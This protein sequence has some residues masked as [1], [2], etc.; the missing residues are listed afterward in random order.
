M[1]KNIHLNIAIICILTAATQA[2]NAQ[3]ITRDAKRVADGFYKQG[4]Y[5]SAA[6]Y[7]EQSLTGNGTRPGTALYQ[8]QRT[9]QSGVK[10]KITNTDTYYKLGESYRLLNNYSQAEGWYERVVKEAAPAYPLAALYYGISLRANAKY[11]AAEKVLH[12]FLDTYKTKDQYQLQAKK[13]IADL[14]FIQ[15]HS[16]KAAL[17]LSKLGNSMNTEGANYAAAWLNENT[18]IFTSTRSEDKAKTGK[19]I[20]TNALYT[21]PV[22][23]EIAG[24][25][26]KLPLPATDEAE[27]GVAAVS[28]DGNTLFFTG[29]TVPASG[30]KRSAI[31]ASK[32]TA[33]GWSAATPL[34]NGI[35]GTTYSARQPFITSD[36][37]YL[38]FASDRSGGVGG[39]DIWYA[40]INSKGEP[41]KAANAGPVI[42]TKGNEEAPFYHTGSK[43]L[44]FA[45]NGR[46]GMGGY[47]LY[48]AKGAINSW[49]EPEN[50][51]AP[52]NSVKDDLYF[53]SRGTG[54]LDHALLSSDRA[55]ACCLE[56][57]AIHTKATPVAVVN[58]PEKPAPVVAVT[59]PVPV[60]TKPEEKPLLVIREVL[61]AFNE[62]SIDTASVHYLDQ[63]ANYLL[64]NPFA[65]I[66]VGAH[67][68]GKG[69]AAYNLQLSEKRAKACVAYLV[70]KGIAADRLLPKGYGECCPVEKETTEAGED[71]PAAREKNRRLEIKVLDK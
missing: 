65:K 61:F 39:F 14:V 6:K 31:Y 18:L 54:L 17:V 41:G 51:G 68:D 47:D 19:T 20:Y 64:A 40:P 4:D 12:R 16:P 1:N 30:V 37:K 52:V 36:G 49:S 70:G 62:A 56:L 33:D 69:T 9:V 53:V 43:T 10:D 71:L 28:A 23:N 8:M 45:S 48:A 22:Q 15:Q 60:A 13:E 58:T 21:A 32:R 27:Q 55:S 46:T 63:V 26:T 7:Y 44:V 38:L 25:V 5:S 57:F 24:E 50:L 2:G 59:P 34:Q 35:N 11:P 29:W 66:E 3:V 67:T 42:N